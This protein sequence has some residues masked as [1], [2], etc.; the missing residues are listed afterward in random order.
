MGGGAAL[1]TRGPCTRH[2]LQPE[3]ASQQNAALWFMAV[4]FFSR[5][6][7][8]GSPGTP[9]MADV[10]KV[11]RSDF[12]VQEAEAWSLVRDRNMTVEHS[13]GCVDKIHGPGEPEYVGTATL[14]G[15]VSPPLCWERAACSSRFSLHGLLQWLC[16]SLLGQALS[17][18]GKAS[19]ILEPPSVC[20]ASYTYFM[21]HVLHRPASRTECLG[22]CHRHVWVAS[23]A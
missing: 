23:R 10:P 11:I 22:L 13:S 3:S 8:L 15:S 2:H 20:S 14:S 4:S 1:S 12:P 21:L 17:E 18:A 6:F 9:P 5:T 7:A 16:D 19:H